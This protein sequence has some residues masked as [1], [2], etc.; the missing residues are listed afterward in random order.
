MIGSDFTVQRVTYRTKC[1]EC[2]KILRLGD[3]SLVSMRGGKVRKRV[4]SEECRL[5][6]DDRYWRGKAYERSRQAADK[7]E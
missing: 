1:G 7:G 3:N 6:F 4:C 2:H 5:V